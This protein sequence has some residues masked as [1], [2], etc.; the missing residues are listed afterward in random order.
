MD[1]LLFA[2][3]TTV[4]GL[5]CKELFNYSFAILNPHDRLLNIPERNSK[6]RKYTFGELLWYLSGKDDVA[7][8]NR[9]SKFWSNI[10][11]DGIHANSAY[12][13]YIFG[14]MRR[15]GDGV[16]Y[17]FDHPGKYSQWEWCK[18][19]IRNDPNTREAIINIKPVQM[20]DTKDVVC[21][22]AL[23]FYQRNGKLYLTTYMRS[24]DA[25][26]GL[27]YDVYMF[28]FLQELMANELGLLL[29]EYTHVVT[30]LHIYEKDWEFMERLVHAN[31]AEMN[32][33]DLMPYI[34]NDFR[35][36]DL[37]ILLKYEKNLA[38]STEEIKK[39][40]HLSLHLLSY[41][42]DTNNVRENF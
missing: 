16:D 9:Y 17:E 20:Y 6:I 18:E 8:I 29:G 22:L 30:N 12:G 10:S 1:D 11:D 27:T 21:T 31:R 14:S 24:N 25:V 2:P 26:K 4:R 33:V 40:S 13:K 38:I 15:K 37:P 19:L 35:A 32:D 42:E 23:N 41:L 5:T 36:V 3:T 28:T 34:E 39:L 7:T